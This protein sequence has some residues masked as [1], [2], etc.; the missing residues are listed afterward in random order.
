[1]SKA[2]IIRKIKENVSKNKETDRIMWF[3]MW[4]FLSV[5][6]FGLALFP[7]FYFLIERRNKH[8]FRQKELENLLLRLKGMEKIDSDKEYITK[9]NSILW[10]LSIILI[11]PVIIIAYI[12]T[13]ELILHE[14]EQRRFFAVFLPDNDFPTRKINLKFY[15]VLTLATL[16]IGAIYWF[17][18][19]FNYYN[20]HFIKQW[21][22][23]DK[24]V[25]LLES[26][27]NE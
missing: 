17:Y 6:S 20:D 4:F 10:A 25:K 16:G 21:V 15:L 19:I 23:E 26:E 1:M 14:E 22:I 27:F 9:R 13:K 3:S 7:M 11:F 2:E 24:I 8:F 18:K 12:L 5:A